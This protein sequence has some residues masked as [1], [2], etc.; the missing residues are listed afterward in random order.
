MLLVAFPWLRSLQKPRR[1]VLCRSIQRCRT[2]GGHIHP[3]PALQ[4][5]QWVPEPRD[6]DRRPPSHSQLPDK[7]DVH[8]ELPAQWRQ[9]GPRSTDDVGTSFWGRLGRKAWFPTLA[10][11][12]PRPSLGSRGPRDLLLLFPVRMAGLCVC[13]GVPGVGT[14][15]QHPSREY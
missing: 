11:T 15:R 5:I 7:V 10:S 14:L 2:I 12:C 13:E 8:E 6:R 1:I 9:E 3:Q 4:R